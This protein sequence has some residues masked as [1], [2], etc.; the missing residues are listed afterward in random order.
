MTP[1]AELMATAHAAVRAEL[2]GAVGERSTLDVAVHDASRVEWRARLP[3]P[4]R[5]TVRYSVEAELEL[6]EGLG[7]RLP[8]DRLQGLTRLEGPHAMAMSPDAT[9]DVIRRGAVALVQ[10]LKRAREG[11]VRHAVAAPQEGMVSAEDFLALWLDF[12]L[13]ALARERRSLAS[14]A[15]AEP[16]Q[17][18]RERE[19]ADELASVRFL[20][21]IAAAQQALSARRDGQSSSAEARL[22]T[23]LRTEMDHRH[24]RGYVEPDPSQPLTLERYVERAGR[25]KQH[26]QAAMAL[27]RQVTAIDERVE[28]WM[29]TFAALV[30]GALAFCL[31]LLLAQWPHLPQL[32]W[33]SSFVLLALITGVAY[34]ARDRIKEIGRSW[35]TG[36]VYRLHAQRVVRC[37]LPASGE[38]VVQAKESYDAASSARPDP[39]NPE[40]GA[41]LGVT[42]VHHLHRGRVASQPGLSAMGVTHIRQTFRFDLSPLF[43]RLQDEHKLVPV[44]DPVSGTASF[45]DAPRRYRVPLQLELQVGHQR[46]TLQATMVLDKRGLTRIER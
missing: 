12:A 1:N 19:L 11:F 21:F 41:T 44:M 4:R 24:A 40:S 10:R 18:Q 13:E 31:Q 8:A 7:T 5:G 28:W 2:Y 20:E 16:V 9:V 34:A 27:N 6:P 35:L 26:F 43:A 45:V 29:T 42:S 37:R 36:R 17:C 32:R 39:L 23:A 22:R 3:L 38:L 30:A 46:Q 15:E 14:P 33:G 25:L